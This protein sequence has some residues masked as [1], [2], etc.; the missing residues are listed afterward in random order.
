MAVLRR[1]QLSKS[2]N[3]VG[4]V[5]RTLEMTRYQ[6]RKAR[7]VTSF[8]CRIHSASQPSSPRSENVQIQFIIQEYEYLHLEASLTTHMELLPILSISMADKSPCDPK[9]Q[10][11]VTPRP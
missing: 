4:G 8:F 6:P 11:Y 9:A 2:L 7:D 1:I 10:V 5:K 3:N